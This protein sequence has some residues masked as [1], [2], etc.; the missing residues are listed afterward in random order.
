M[1]RFGKI[2][3]YI[4]LV[5]MWILL[6]FSIFMFFSIRWMLNMWASLNIEELLYHLQAPLSGTDYHFYIHYLIHSA[7]F[8]LISIITCIVLLCFLKKHKAMVYAGFVVLSV[9]LLVVTIV[10][11]DKKLGVRDYIKSSYIA[12]SFIEDNYVEPDDLD[13]EFPEKKKNLIYIYLESMEMTYTD[14]SNGGAFKENIIPELVDLSREGEDFSGDSP[15]INGAISLYGSEWTMG[16]MFAQSTGLPLKTGGFDGNYISSQSKMYP[17]VKGIGDLLG[18]AGYTNELLIGSNATFGGR[19]TFFKGHGDYVIA[20]HPYAIAQGWIPSDYNVFWGYEDEKLFEFARNEATR[21]SKEDK[22]FNLTMLTVDTHFEDG[23]VCRLCEDKYNNGDMY[24]NVMACSSKQVGRFVDWLKR[25]DFYDDTV[26]VLVGDHPTMDSDFC[27][28]VPEDYQRRVITTIINADLKCERNDYRSYSTMDMFPTTLAAMGVCIPGDRLGLGV[29]LY[30]DQD[31]LIEKY[32]RDYCN[33]E[34]VRKSEFMNSLNTIEF[35]DD[36]IAY[37]RRDSRIELI[38]NSDGTEVRFW[39]NTYFNDI[40]DFDRLEADVVD[41]TTQTA[42]TIS[43]GYYYKEGYYSTGF[44]KGYNP[45]NITVN[46]YLVDTDGE[47]Y[48]VGSN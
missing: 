48:L 35:N 7:S 20:D 23:Y 16:A 39:T 21:L 44:F 31:T 28:D 42:D 6:V 45:D 5:F 18:E 47:R 2:I 17:S 37:I 43:V 12:S 1:Q 22:P 14:S 29:N 11:L 19:D 25:Q 10:K 46:V 24:S 4:G 15:Y 30:S 40:E 34:I 38:N 9:L 27:N 36:L 41:E 13:I 26:I 32:G 3:K 8:I 33:E